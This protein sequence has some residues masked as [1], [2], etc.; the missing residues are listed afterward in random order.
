[1]KKY[2]VKST[3]NY[4]LFKFL[5]QNRPTNSVQSERHIEHLCESM[6]LRGF[7]DP[8]LVNKEME[9]LD[10]QHRF[11]AGQKAGSEILYMVVEADDSIIPSLNTEQL[12]WKLD[13]YLH[14][15]V[16][17]GKES[18]KKI[19]DFMEKYNMPL[20]ETIALVKGRRGGGGGSAS[21]EFRD[22]VIDVKDI[23]LN[24][25]IETVK[26]VDEIRNF[27]D[28][29]K[30]FSDSTRFISAV[31]TL[32]TDIDYDHKYFMKKLGMMQTD[33]VACRSKHEYLRL[34]QQVYNWKLR[35]RHLHIVKVAQNV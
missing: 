17:K 22:G 1:M 3:T 29:Y 4:E 34:F 5:P 35:K 15:Y 2:E 7:I 20:S 19:E 12:N 21:K 27:S 11:L 31:I 32:V 25:A 13:T 14:Y 18:Y 16:Q 30:L 28:S 26:K 8:I 9:I 24:W 6:K 23:T 33:I 10:G